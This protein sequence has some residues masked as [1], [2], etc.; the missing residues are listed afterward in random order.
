M[1]TIIVGFG[2]VGKALYG[3]LK[4]FYLCEAVDGNVGTANSFDIMHICFPYS[5]KFIDYAKEYQAKYKPKYTII[6]ST[7]PVGTSRVLNALHSPIRGRHPYL[8]ESLRVFVKFIGG[9]KSSEIADY[10]RRA[11]LKIQLCEKS[12]TTELMKLLDTEYYRTCIEF[13]QK[14]KKLCDKNNV[15]FSEAY[16]LA[17]L[18]YNEGYLK[19]GNSEY[20]RP[21]LQPIM[22][23]IGGH[24]LLPNKKLLEGNA[25][26]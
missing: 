15:P 7:V 16:T 8:E 5:N 3:V 18:T 6:H 26:I 10:F 1:K 9:E 11:G 22:T 17:N 4:D 19:M 21:V 20:Q 14:A 23:E 24:C 25:E 12:E 13:T 2:E